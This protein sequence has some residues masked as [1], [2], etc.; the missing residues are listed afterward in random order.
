MTI[1][2]YLF[3]S[4]HSQPFQVG[5]P[6]PAMLKAQEDEA[7]QEQQQMEEK[8]RKFSEDYSGYRDSGLKI[9]SAAAYAA[10]EGFALSAEQVEQLSDASR[11][12]NQ[13]NYVKVY[14][15]EDGAR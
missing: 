2:S 4:P 6:D 15:Q 13:G 5:R 3:Q 10:D 8:S 9:K 1:S 14:A 11:K 7:K 12:T